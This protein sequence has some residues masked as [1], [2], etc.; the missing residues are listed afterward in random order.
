MAIQRLL[1]IV[2]GK[3]QEYVA[4]VT[5][6]GAASAG[7]IPALDASGRLD[8]TTMPSGVGADT[9]TLP[10]SEALSA[11]AFVNIWSNA[12]TPSVRNA[13]GSTAGK[14]AD[15][16]VLAAVTS[17]GS[18]TVYLSGVNTAVSGQTAGLVYLSDTTVG[19]TMAT[20][21]STAGH[22]FQQIGMAVSATS[23]QFDPQ[24]PIV[25]A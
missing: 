16:F 24:Q 5:S 17:G 19:G 1:A 12:G 15:G 18:A 23:I 4:T 3:V 14:Q 21:A 6:S 2:S 7:Q 13:D 8:S 9:V 11:G 10:A 22:T 25:R 20:G